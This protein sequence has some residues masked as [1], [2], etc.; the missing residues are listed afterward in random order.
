MRITGR[1][2]ILY[3]VKIQN[4]GMMYTIIQYNYAY[5]M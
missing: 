5:Y 4:Y 1:I 3:L 2:I